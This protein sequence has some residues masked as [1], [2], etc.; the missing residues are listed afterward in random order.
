VNGGVSGTQFV[1]L[2]LKMTA[3]TSKKAL[4]MAQLV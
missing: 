4:S 1:T 3:F 2:M